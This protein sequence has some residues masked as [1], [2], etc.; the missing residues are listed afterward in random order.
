MK[1][2]YVVSIVIL[3]IAAMLLSLCACSAAQTQS[4][5]PEAAEPG[6][7]ADVSEAT[8]PVAPEATKVPESAAQ[9]PVVMSEPVYPYMDLANEAF[10][11]DFLKVCEETEIAVD[12][13]SDFTKIEGGYT[14]VY[15]TKTIEM[16]VDGK[17]VQSMSC[18]GTTFYTASNKLATKS[19][20]MAMLDMKQLNSVE[21]GVAEAIKDENGGEMDR[22][23]YS[24]QKNA[25]GTETMTGTAKV[26]DK[27]LPFTCAYRYDGEFECVELNI[28]EAAAKPEN[29]QS[30]TK[31]DQ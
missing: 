30:Q 3:L 2:S 18:N 27:D 5:Q 23:S 19:A 7:V 21:N 15:S 12:F 24:T 28:G 13:L 31:Q 17:N 11:D 20:V 25:D 6:S 8:A 4:A 22:C 1:K 10:Y 29:T 14:F 16:M 26:D 9:E